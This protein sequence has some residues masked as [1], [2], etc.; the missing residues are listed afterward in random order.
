MLATENMFDITRAEHS[1]VSEV[2]FD[3]IPFGRVFSDHMFSM[4]YRDGKWGKGEILP[5]Q[6]LSINPAS[7][8]I[9][10]GQSIFEGMKAF[11]QDD[12][13][14]SLFRPLKNV[15]RFNISAE[16][17]CMPK[18]EESTF[19]KALHQ[20]I[21][22]DSVW[23]PKDPH[24]ALY[25]RPFMFAI[26]EY[27]GVKPSES[28]RFMIFTCP[29]GK[30]YTG[31]VKVKIETRYARSMPG[32]TGYAK[33]AGNYAGALY[34][35]KLAQEEGYQQLIWTDAIEHKYIEE[36][37]TMNVMFK[38]GN[39]IITPPVSETILKGITRDSV[40]TLAKEWGYD[41]QERP[42]EFTEILDLA[43]EGKL[44]EAFGV[45]TAAT[46]APISIIGYDGTDHELPEASKREFGPRVSSALDA[47][48]RGTSEDYHGWNY[49]IN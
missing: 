40:L 35:A 34:P 6:N 42:V 22:I 46:I 30:Y 45:G 23:I 9:H 31:D 48:K 24:G 8:V 4:E 1:R 16:R 2:D 7:S 5:F 28:Y 3:N 13:N 32:G 44:D 17:M 33:S 49:L 11:R 12:G 15:E 14:I 37:G 41:V 18:I 10:Y 29:V 27:I 36:S 43:K 39:T 26:D 47:I 20:L 38:T 21:N 25:V 19:L